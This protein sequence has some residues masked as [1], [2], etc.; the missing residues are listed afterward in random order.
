VTQLAVGGAT[1]RAAQPGADE[2]PTGTR[3]VPPVSS[4]L[5]AMP[6]AGALM[7]P[8]LRLGP[9][10]SLHPLRFRGTPLGAALRHA[11]LELPQ[12]FAPSGV[13]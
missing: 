13:D 10:L 7:L 11:L 5:L 3:L 8:A 6:V 1:I 9:S 2:E 4:S 12:Q